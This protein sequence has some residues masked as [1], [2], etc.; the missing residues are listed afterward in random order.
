MKKLGRI[1]L[2]LLVSGGGMATPAAWAG[3]TSSSRHKE[4][5]DKASKDKESK[6]KKSKEDEESKDKELTD[7]RAPGAPYK[8]Y[9]CLDAYL[10]DGFLERLINYYRLEW[11][12]DKPPSD[13][14]APS[15]RRAGWPDAPAT[16]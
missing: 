8:K 11:G 15:A 2:A 7:C 9:E 14:D 16:T 13:P 3:D 5:K 6:D 12:R 1:G 4:L 10:G